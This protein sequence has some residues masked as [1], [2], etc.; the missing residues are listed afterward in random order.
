[1]PPMKTEEFR[2]WIRKRYGGVVRIITDGT[3]K[4]SEEGHAYIRE[5]LFYA[6]FD[7][8]KIYY[9]TR[10]SISNKKKKQ[11]LCDSRFMIELKNGEWY[12]V[13]HDAAKK[14]ADVFVNC[15]IEDMLK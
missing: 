7:G 15:V 2:S 5:F 9:N 13:N 4:A 1:M 12:L 11:Y 10:M 3:D 8:K 14:Y 6:I